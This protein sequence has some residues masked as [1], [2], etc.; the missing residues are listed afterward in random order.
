MHAWG[1]E[2]IWMGELAYMVGELAHRVL[3][4]LGCPEFKKIRNFGSIS[5]LNF[6]V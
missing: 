6:T 1:S 2:A 4:A 3:A 5:F